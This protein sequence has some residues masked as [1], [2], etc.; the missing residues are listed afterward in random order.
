MCATLQIVKLHVTSE[1][2]QGFEW[3][4]DVGLLTLIDASTEQFCKDRN[5][6]GISA[7]MQE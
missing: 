3:Q 1:V 4:Y 5:S 6:S 2:R 7:R